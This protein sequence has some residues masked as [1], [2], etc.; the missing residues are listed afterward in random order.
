MLSTHYKEE[1]LIREELI[2]QIGMGE[3]VA[4]IIVDRGH[5]GGAERHE[6]TTTGIIVVYNVKTN[7]LVTKLIARPEQIERYFTQVDVYGYN[8]RPAGYR[9]ILAIAEEHKALKYNE[10]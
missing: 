1:R 3:T 2:K 9:K 5:A 6:I 10:V 7:K 8:K 4:Q